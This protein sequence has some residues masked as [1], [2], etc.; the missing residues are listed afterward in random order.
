MLI[1]YHCFH[2]MFILPFAIGS[3]SAKV[4]RESDTGS[5]ELQLTLPAVITADLRLN[6]PRYATLPNI[7]K[8]RPA[9][10]FCC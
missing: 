9:L 8:V 3:Q 6:E 10:V 5:E 2:F 1:F 4:T 7:M